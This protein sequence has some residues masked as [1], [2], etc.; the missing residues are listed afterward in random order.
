MQIDFYFVGT[1]NRARC[2]DLLFDGGQI[3]LAYLATIETRTRTST[4]K[5]THKKRRM[6]ELPHRLQ[7]F[8]C[9][10]AGLSIVSEL[11]STDSVLQRVGL[12]A[13][14]LATRHSRQ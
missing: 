14:P 5:H 1:T 2:N 11:A 7:P 13:L 8:E 3:E 4:P 6:A 10:S 9:R 12:V